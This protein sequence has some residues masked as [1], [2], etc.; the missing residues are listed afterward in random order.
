MEKFHV[1]V[2]TKLDK[3]DERID[4]VDKTL[5]KNTS[6]LEEHMRRTELL[7]TDLAPIKTHVAQVSGVLKFLVAVA[8]TTGAIQI[9]IKLLQ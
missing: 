5:I 1:D 3:L 6:S 2:I 8:S 9:I 4:S 7:E